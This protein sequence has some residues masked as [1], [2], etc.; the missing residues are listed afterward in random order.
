MKVLDPVGVK[1][2]DPHPTARRAVHRP[3]TSAG[4]NEI[5]CCDGHDKLLSYG[6]SVWGIRDKYSRKWLGLWCLPAQSNRYPIV[7]AYLWL[8]V[9]QKLGGESYLRLQITSADP[10]K[11]CP[12]QPS[13]DFGS[14]TVV[15]YGLVNPLK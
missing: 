2:R 9:V 5:W 7:V 11:E 10:P 8:S 1:L 14:E 6:F 3:L 12:A 15:I 4:P 13:T